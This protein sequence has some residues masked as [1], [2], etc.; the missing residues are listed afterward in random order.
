MHNLYEQLRDYSHSEAYPFHMPGHKRRMVDFGNPFEIDI[1]E[2]DGFDNLH[3][4]EGI[5]REAQQR[6]ARLYGADETF[7]C[8]NGSTAGILSAVSSCVP[9]GGRLLMAR[10]CHKSAYNAA[11]LRQLSVTYLYPQIIPEIGINGGLLPEEVEEMLIT[12]PDIRAVLI[13]SPTYEGIVADVEGIAK[14]AHRHD[15]PLIVDEA[16]GAHFGFHPYFP[17]SAV[18]MGADIVIQS[19]HKTLPALTQTALVHRNGN[20]TDRERLAAYM[21]IYQTSSPSYVLMASMDACIRLLEEK[22]EEVFD[23]YVKQLKEFERQAGDLQYVRQFCPPVGK[24]VFARD[25]SKLIL[26][27]VD[28][29]MSGNELYQKLR[30]E[31]GLQLEMAAGDYAL[32]MTSAADTPE[33]FKR[34]L[35]AMR[36]IDHAVNGAV[37]RTADYAVDGAVGRTA[38]HAVNEAA[39]RTVDHAVDRAYS[40]SADCPAGKGGGKKDS[41]PK[42]G[43]ALPQENEVILPIWR[44]VECPKKKVNLEE[45]EGHISGE[46]IYL[47]PP[48]IPLLVPGEKISGEFLK[49]VLQYRADGLNIQGLSDYDARIIEIVDDRYSRL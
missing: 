40:A 3:H 36:E 2:I 44:A 49:K 15:V 6:A 5:L 21:G 29:S 32:A 11:F 34:L 47:Y 9:S 25:P 37:G 31:Y 24:N 4:A 18:K 13:T 33:G 30:I 20:L 35:E 38:D 45:A 42:Y 23:P 28:G 8:V 39:G 27:A 17:E 7:F 43:M 19:L 10:N 14:A 41:V 26:T 16:H 12:Y 46:Y 22:A 48:G 1:T